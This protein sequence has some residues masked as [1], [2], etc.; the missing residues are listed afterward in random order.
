MQEDLENGV[1]VLDGILPVDPKFGQ[2]E[3]DLGLGDLLGDG[4]LVNGHMTDYSKMNGE[5]RSAEV[6][7]HPAKR[8]ALEGVVTNGVVASNG[9]NGGGMRVGG[10]QGMVIVSQAGQQQTAVYREALQYRDS[11]PKVPDKVY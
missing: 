4:K 6:E 8:Q 11:P 9:V 7:S 10:N 2:L 1:S 5:K 3:G